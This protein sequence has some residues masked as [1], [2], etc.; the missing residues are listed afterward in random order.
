MSKCIRIFLKDGRFLGLVAQHCFISSLYPSGQV[1]GMGKFNL[2]LPTPQIIAELSTF[3]YGISHVRSSQRRTPKDQMSTFS[4][5]GSFR[6]TS[7]AIQATVPAKL[8]QV[9]CSPQVRLVPKSL[10]FKISFLPIRTLK[11]KIG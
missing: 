3:W 4:L 2:L 9:D 7:G 8:M 5:Q 10:I 6:M 1:L 11:N